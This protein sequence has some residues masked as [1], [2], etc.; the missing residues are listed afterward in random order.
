[1][2]QRMPINS[3][4]HQ[5]WLQRDS[6]IYRTHRLHMLL[7]WPTGSSMKAAHKFMPKHSYEHSS[8]LI[9]SEEA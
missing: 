3:S 2:L 9:P 4:S 1:M 8:P 5:P 6:G 7:T